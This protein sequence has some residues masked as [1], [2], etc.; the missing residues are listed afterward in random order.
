MSLL[1]HPCVYRPEELRALGRLLDAAVPEAR[2]TFEAYVCA[3]YARAFVHYNYAWCSAAMERFRVGE[4]ELARILVDYYVKLS[5]ARTPHAAGHE[6]A[7]DVQAALLLSDCRVFFTL[8][9]VVKAHTAM[10]DSGGPESV[11]LMPVE[12]V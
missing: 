12:L 3:A 11:Q 5:S 10:I 8:E 9:E 1:C 4:A 6:R 2:Q 7:A